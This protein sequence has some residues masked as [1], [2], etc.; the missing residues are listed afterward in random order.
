M[1]P[2]GSQNYPGEPY[3]PE[4]CKFETGPPGTAKQK[5]YTMKFI[6][7]PLSRNTWLQ[8]GIIP[9]SFLPWA[10]PLKLPH[11]DTPFRN[12]SISSNHPER[13]P[14]NGML[15]SFTKPA[16][17]ELEN[18]LNSIGGNRELHYNAIG[19]RGTHFTI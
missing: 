11:V 19:N 16:Q 6:I 13:M 1:E 9:R 12:A 5:Q 17:G 14:I 10:I 18:T 15:I 8:P 4:A 2:K 7:F 3:C